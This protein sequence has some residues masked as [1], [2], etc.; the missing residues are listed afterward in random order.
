[1]SSIFLPCALGVAIV[2][3]AL[4]GYSRE[5]AAKR[6]LPSVSEALF[7]DAKPADMSTDAWLRARA[8]VAGSLDVREPQIDPA[9][10]VDDLTR[11]FSGFPIGSVDFGLVCEDCCPDG[12]C[13]AELAAMLKRP[14][15]TVGDVLEVVARAR[16]RC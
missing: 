16:G 11:Q 2:G 7:V 6:R 9:R 3:I 8:C 1:M 15:T 13:R 12:R 4:Y 10:R 5:R 14:A